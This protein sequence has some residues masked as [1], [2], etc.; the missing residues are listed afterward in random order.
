METPSND[1]EDSE[2][3]V[4]YVRLLQ[5]LAGNTLACIL[6]AINEPTF[7]E[8]QRRLL[9]DRRV[10]MQQKGLE[11]L[12]DRLH[13]S[14]PTSEFVLSVESVE[15]Q[16]RAARDPKKKISAE[17]LLRL[18][19]RPLTTKRTATLLPRI[20]TISGAAKGSEFCAGGATVEATHP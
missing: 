4:Q 12:L 2:E 20:L 10:V 13:Q 14:V 8:C 17:D 15:E 11:T 6:A 16:R 5:L 19:A 1:S 3:H 18:R 9:S 7:V